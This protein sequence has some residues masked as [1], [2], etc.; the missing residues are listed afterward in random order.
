MKLWRGMILGL[1]AGCLI[2]LWLMG[3][4]TWSESWQMRWD[5][6]A[7]IPVTLSNKEP[8][9]ESGPNTE[10]REKHPEDRALYS[11]SDQDLYVFLGMTAAELRERWGEPQR[12][13]PS[14]FGYKWW[15]YHDDWE[16]Y[17]QIGMKD[18]RVNTVYTNA[19]GWQW[20]DWRVG[21]AKA[22]WKENWS[23][24][25]EYAFT[26]QWGYYTFVLFDDDKRERPLHFE[27][28]MAV[29]L[30]IDLHAGESIAGIRLMDL[31]TLLLH[32]P[33][34]LNYIGSLPEP[35]PLSES[36]RQAVAQANERQIFDLVNV[37]RTAMELSPFDWH[38]EVAEIAR[39]HSRDMLEHN[40][41]DHYSP[42]YGGLGERL[43]RGGVDF[44]RAGENIA[45][46]Y[47]DA[48]DV[49]HGWLNSPGHR[50]NI[51]EP[52]FTHLGVGV[53]DKYYTQNFVKQ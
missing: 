13:D 31:E 3:W 24:Q 7:D 32:R 11:V 35:S 27:G 39:E 41:F 40:Y 23:Q 51:V 9:V 42:R 17:I 16:T 5:E 29:Q 19:P 52:A 47:V 43:Q 26:Y 14:A 2:H 37:T 53:V 4:D 21:Q 38:D 8:A 22:E 44:A 49:H 50:Q 33:Y 1:M 34:T 36:E 25:E 10:T 12:I 46:N 28:D 45:W 18:G 30:Y 6:F 15:I 48:P 20:K